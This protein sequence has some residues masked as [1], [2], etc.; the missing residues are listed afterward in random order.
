MGNCDK[1]GSLMYI[2]KTSGNPYCS[3]K[4]WLNSQ[5]PNNAQIPQIQAP[6]PVKSPN[7]AI[8]EQSIVLNR[9]EKPNSYEFGPAN[10]RHKVY[11]ESVADLKL[12]I[13]ALVEAGLLQ[14]LDL[15]DGQTF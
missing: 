3:K 12:Q 6:Q 2:S 11:Y 10:N 5:Q 1:C 15:K 4:C 8:S 7:T 9:T 13:D 14:P